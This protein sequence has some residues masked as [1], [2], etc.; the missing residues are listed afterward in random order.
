MVVCLDGSAD[1]EAAL[2]WAV[3]DAVLRDQHLTLVHVISPM[4]GG[5]AGIGM[6][7]PVLA[8]DLTEQQR[9]R[10]RDVLDDSRSLASAVAGDVTLRIDTAAPIGAVVPTLVE[11]STRTG[12]LVLGGRGT[13]AF[14]RLL[15][16]SV[17]TALAHHAH[18]PVTIVRAQ[19]PKPAAHAPVLLGVD[20]SPGSL[21]AIDLAFEEAARRGAELVA[22]YAHS[23]SDTTEP[24]SV[25]QW[26]SSSQAEHELMQLLSPY[27]ER[28]PDVEVRYCTV[29][30]RPARHLIERAESAQLV[31]VGSRGRGG[32]A[33]MLLGSVS[34][35]LIHATTTPVII[36]RPDPTHLEH[37]P[38]ETVAAQS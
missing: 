21:P 22:L 29:P 38:T 19:G 26:V 13:G 27:R 31:I 14:D 23:D 15:L 3:R 10:A 33:G 12:M 5:F 11:L 9:A 18:C 20:G 34:T 28:F 17:S 7:T 32:I 6:P 1:S 35:A 24:T 8:Q 25:P 16:G 36:A 37:R 30:D 2:R 4:I